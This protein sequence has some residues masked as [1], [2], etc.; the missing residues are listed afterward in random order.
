[1][2]ASRR[3]R[4][5][6]DRGRTSSMRS[7]VKGCATCSSSS[8]PT[9]RPC[10]T[11]GRRASS[12]PTSCYGSTTARGAGPRSARALASLRRNDDGEAGRGRLRR[13]RP[14]SAIGAATRVLPHRLGPAGSRRSTSSSCI[15]RTCAGERPGTA[16]SP[17]GSRCGP[18]AQRRHRAASRSGRLLAGAG[19]WPGALASSWWTKNSLSIRNRRTQPMRKNPGGGPDLTRSASEANH[20][21]PV[22]R[23]VAPPTGASSRVRP[24]PGAASRSGC[25]K[26]EVGSKLA[27]GPTV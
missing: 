13:A 27:S 24:D 20:P 1:M 12:L 8:G 5:R 10:S 6:R 25:A 26:H 4:V 3:I 19:L 16:D 11:H 17:A 2:A 22:Q 21:R 15:T 7:S 14:A 9:R 18:V 23:Y